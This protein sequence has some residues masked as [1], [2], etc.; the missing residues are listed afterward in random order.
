MI[1]LCLLTGICSGLR[2]QAGGHDEVADNMLIYQ[3][4]VGGWP[5]HI[6]NE[7]IDYHKKLSPAEKA[8][9]IDDASMNDATIDN[10]ATTKEIRYLL[11]AYRQTANHDYL[12]GAERGIRYLLRMQ[13]ANGGFPQFYPDTS[14]YR[15]EITYNDNAMVN[16]LNVLYDVSQSIGDL[17]QVDPSLKAPAAD[18]VRRGI[19]CILATQIKVNGRLT[20]W[21]A[22]YDEHSYAPAKARSY[23]LPSLSGEE[24]VGIV[25]FLMRQPDPSPAIR[26][27]VNSAVEWFR[28]A[29]IEGFK[30]VN[31]YDSTQ[32]GGRDRVIQPSPGSVLW[33][34]F[35]DIQTNK[36]FFCGRDGIRKNAVA[37]I[38]HERRVGYAWY[39]EWPRQLL[40]KDYPEWQAKFRVQ[41][42]GYKLQAA[43]YKLQAPSYKLQVGSGKQ[44]AGLLRSYELRASGGEQSYG[45]RAS[46]YRQTAVTITVDASG[47]GDFLTVQDAVNSLPDESSAPRVI[48]IRKGVYNQK[49]L[50]EKNN[51]VLRGEDRD[52]TILT[53]AQARDA[54]RCDHKDDWG[55]ATL[56]LRGSDITLENLT[57]QN[58]YG[59]DHPEENVTIACEADTAAHRKTVR[60]DGHQMALRS[61]QT[62]RLKVLNCVLK[63]YGGDTVSPW[64]VSGGMFYFKDCVMEGGVDFYC[65]RGWAYA[66]HCSFKSDTGPAAI[67]HDGSADPDSKTVLKD[68]SFSGY[69]GFKLGRY[70]RD[71]Q[72]YLINCSFAGNMAD[73]DIYLVEGTG[74]KI[75]WGRRVYYYGCSKPGKPYGWY[76]N[77][78]DQAPG[79]PDPASIGPE[80]VFRGKWSPKPDGGG[81]GGG[82]AAG[83][84][85]AGVGGG[86]PATA[87]TVPA[88]QAARMSITVMNDSADA[89][90]LKWT[91]DA[92]VVWR[93]LEYLWYNT[94]DA[95]YFRFIQHEIDRLVDKDGNIGGGYKKEDYNLDNVLCGRILL[96]LYNVTN[97]EKYYK[98]ALSLREQLGDQPRTRSGGFWHKQRYPWQV[99][100]DGLYMAQ[101]FYAQW[102]AQFHEDTTFNDIARQFIMIERYTRDEK[103]GLLY[104][105]WDESRQE[106]W[107]DKLSGRSPN[108]WGRAMGWYGM[109]L[110]DALDYFPAD[111]PGR[112]SL[113][114]ILQRFATA[115]TKVQDPETGLW[116][117]IL[118]KPGSS[119]GN[120]LEASASCMFVYTLEKAVRR[121]YLPASYRA[122]AQKGYAGILERFVTP[123][124]GGG[125][126]LQGTVSV[127]GLGGNPY[128]DGSFAYYMK[129][130]V[131]END[132]KGVGAFL[133]A[134]GEMEMIPTLSEGKG[135]T[136]LLDYYFNNEHHKDV[137][138]AP[139]R[140]HYTW[141]DQANSGFSLWG[142]IFRDHGM[143]TDTL[144][145]APTAARLKKASIYI[146]VDPDNEKEVPKPNYPTDADIDHIYNWVKE[147]GVLVLMSN[148]SGNAEFTHFNHLAAR[149]GIQFNLD[150]YHQVTGNHFEM[151]AFTMTEQDA[152]FKT[153]KKIYIKELST[154]SLSGQAKPYFTDQGHVIMATAKIGKGT[155]F[156]VGDP[157]FY[158]E[159]TDGRK[160]PPDFENYQAA[161]D[162]TGWLIKQIGN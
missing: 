34:R 161:T 73:K 63:A 30:Y 21:C 70:H 55:V 68:C 124:S 1:W 125:T 23:E 89:K 160:L 62:T 31:I 91:Y 57:I 50:I 101:P 127:S 53:F 60:R 26:E 122:A 151:G 43:S 67:W 51:V 136:V 54:W 18:A 108:F 74:N 71:A 96:L 84:G 111:H 143:R 100:L 59:F 20:V 87:A 15:H 128:R 140:F 154:L 134:A 16:A 14:L 61:F 93:G 33:A 44:S 137:T 19:Q 157:W 81:A 114:E 2:A 77:N 27:A 115:V 38:E 141:G 133:L 76:A 56:N 94:G 158:N 52:G 103:T 147:G 149:F 162:L 110:V 146:I 45:L 119:Q 65:P 142:H 46:S 139:V 64:N 118:D 58:S 7:R 82:L 79:S 117:D 153:S 78:L 126:N 86:D 112:K 105:G 83:A 48:L 131:V 80:W 159:Y 39:G 4:T 121:G 29:K 90:P 138:G 22:Q 9:F 8:A 25:E 97:Q 69:D 113:L 106:K 36:P 41:T 24:S 85:L 32:P 123:G 92:G 5:K 49:I 17:A 99:W 104:H 42:A 98:A 155:V 6:G 10:D 3:R 40:E 28:T 130:K 11:M 75:Q 37:E 72:F 145:E 12:A 35:Y 156:A 120:Y 102:A 95:R 13:Y 135:R 107:S 109:A 144:T 66:E 148:D 88:S 47:K 150:N 129:E 132:P 116:W 152:I